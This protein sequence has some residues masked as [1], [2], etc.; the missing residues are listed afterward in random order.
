MIR[1]PG[2]RLVFA[3][4]AAARTPSRHP[5]MER[6]SDSRPDVTGGRTAYLPSGEPRGSGSFC[7]PFWR[8]LGSKLQQGLGGIVKLAACRGGRGRV[9]ERDDNACLSQLRRLPF[10]AGGD[11]LHGLAVFPLPALPAHG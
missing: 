8:R 4:V 11:Q 5:A 3:Q 6:I 1:D 7:P 10:P 9:A 2:R